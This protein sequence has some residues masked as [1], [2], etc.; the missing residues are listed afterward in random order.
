MTKRS[1]IKITDT[2]A[3]SQRVRLL[4]RLQAG[5]VSTFDARHELNIMMPAARVKELRERG[6]PVQTH[7][8][9]LPDAHGHMHTG[10][11]TYYLSAESGPA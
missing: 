11:A 9:D 6:Y 5:P 8:S 2:S 1:R 4:E 7:L 10:V 3:A